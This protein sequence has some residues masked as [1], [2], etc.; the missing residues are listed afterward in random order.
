VRLCVYSRTRWATETVEWA[1][2]LGLGAIVLTLIGLLVYF[3]RRFSAGV[4]RRSPESD[5][6]ARLTLTGSALTA[7]LVGFWVLCLA[8]ITLEPHSA[9]GEIVGQRGGLIAVFVLSMVVFLVAAAVLERLGLPI[10][11]RGDPR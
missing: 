4:Q 7:G 1:F 8:T 2:A 5:L 6:A 3:G 11:K 9:L 10:A